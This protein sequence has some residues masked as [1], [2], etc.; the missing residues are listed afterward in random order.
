MSQR[1][2][3]VRHGNRE[4]FQSPG[5]SKTAQR[6]FDPAL[7][8]DGETQAR[9][10]GLSLQ[11]ERVHCIFASPFLRTIQTASHIADALD[12]SVRLE[13]GIGEILP[14]VKSTPALLPESE[15]KRRFPRID[16]DYTVIRELSYPESSEEGHE[17]A[18]AAAHALTDRFPDKN[19]LMV[20][21]GAPV[22]G[23]VRGLTG[24]KDRITVPLCCIFTLQR[25][26]PGWEVVQLSETSH[27][28]NQETSKRYAH[29]G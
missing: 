5:W 8:A 7:S 29:S 3:I 11:G 25:H 2:W 20:T 22:V 9:E 4:D 28:S 17:R 27:L 14:N 26:G 16:E 13:P 1:I 21:H 24:L 15:R 18:A 23:I 19:L 10:V 6:P 12:L